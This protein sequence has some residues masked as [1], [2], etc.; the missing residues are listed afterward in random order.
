[1]AVAPKEATC[2]CRNALWPRV[3]SGA[4]RTSSDHAEE[5]SGG[6]GRQLRPTRDDP[7]RVGGHDRRR[8]C[9]PPCVSFRPDEPGD[10]AGRK[11]LTR[12]RLDRARHP[13]A[14][15]RAG[16]VDSGR[17]LLHGNAR[18]DDKIRDAIECGVGYKWSR[19]G[20][21]LD[22][23]P[24]LIEQIRREPSVRLEVCTSASARRS[25]ICSSSARRSLPS[26]RSDGLRSAASWSRRPG[27]QD[28][29]GGRRRNG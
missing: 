10:R 16:G 23:A 6:R 5:R 7:P 20:V 29:R 9:L 4:S 18:T 15:A 8:R 14:R 22:Q 17:M 12:P 13:A 26:S 2:V 25:S 28:P 27:R 24:A 1:M 21:S 3:R 11:G 19:F